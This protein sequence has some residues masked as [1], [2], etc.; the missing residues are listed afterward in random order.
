MELR[1]KRVSDPLIRTLRAPGIIQ[2]PG[3]HRGWTF[4]QSAMTRMMNDMYY[5]RLIDLDSFVQGRVGFLAKLPWFL[6]GRVEASDDYTP[7]PLYLSGICRNVRNS[8]WATMVCLVR[9]V[10]TCLEKPPPTGVG[11]Y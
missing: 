5:F 4:V 11:L 6:Q 10:L 9:G 8:L 3:S 2:F 1:Q 7:W